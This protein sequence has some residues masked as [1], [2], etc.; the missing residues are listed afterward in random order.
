MRPFRD[1]FRRKLR[2]SLTIAG[3]T[4]GIWALVV[5]SSMANKISSLV[6]GGSLYYKDKII[7]S[8]ATNPGFG[9]GF[10]PMPMAIAEEIAAIPGVAVAVPEVGMILDPDDRR[11]GFGMP[12]F[13][14]GAVA[15]ADNGYEEFELKASL[16]RLLTEDDEGSV[17]VLLGADLAREFSK[18]PGDLIEIRC[19]DFTVVGGLEPTLTAPDSTARIPLVA[20]QRLL[21]KDAPLI[22]T[23]EMAIDQLISQVIVYPNKGINTSDLAKAIEGEIQQIQTMTGEKFDER[24]GS[25]ITIFNAVIL[26]IALISLA[27]GG[28]SVINTMAMS[29]AERTREIGIKRA[30]GSSRLR[31]MRE[32][33]SEA[34]LIGF[35]GG[36]LGL[37]LGAIIVIIANELGRNSGTVLFELTFGTALFALI[38]STI[39]GMGAG[40]IPAWNAARMDPVEALRHE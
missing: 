22:V 33:V 21:S 8:D 9:F 31:I 12:S 20:A 40:F 5:M 10:T 19:E 18:I 38:F 2:T 17:L 4:I 11:S 6:D 32:L 28:L 27:V 39:L 13:I 29:I 23:Q 35:I 3:I 15:G 26:G 34:G 36:T 24:V 25:S 37:I 30:V 16:G 14:S 1:L 7:I